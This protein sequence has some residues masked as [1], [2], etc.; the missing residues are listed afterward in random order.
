MDA[1]SALMIQERE[2]KKEEETKDEI[3]DMRYE[4]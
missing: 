3:R 1:T 4:I 2:K